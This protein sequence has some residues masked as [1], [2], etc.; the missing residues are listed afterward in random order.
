MFDASWHAYPKVNGLRLGTRTEGHD[1]TETGGR[2]MQSRGNQGK[3]MLSHSF[4]HPPYRPPTNHDG[5]KFLSSYEQF[6]PVPQARECGSPLVTGPVS[7]N[8]RLGTTYHCLFRR[9]GSWSRRLSSSKDDGPW[10]I[11][12]G[13]VGCRT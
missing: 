5:P 6:G 9:P 1:T 11:V 7:S 10:C 3:D 13:V 4:V 8:H 12:V 2:A